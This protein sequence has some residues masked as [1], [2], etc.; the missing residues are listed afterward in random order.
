MTHDAARTR[1]SGPILSNHGWGRNGGAEI[2]VSPA[3]HGG[4]VP[5]DEQFGVLGCRGPAE[6]DQPPA[7][8]DED[9]VEQADGHESS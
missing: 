3:Q 1:R 9:E 5:Q 7:D 6:Q 4:L 8:P 2:G